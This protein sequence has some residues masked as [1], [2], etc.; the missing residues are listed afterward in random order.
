MQVK[1]YLKNSGSKGLR[2]LFVQ[3]TNNYQRERFHFS[4]IKLNPEH[5]DAKKNE[6]KRSCE[7]YSEL[8]EKIKNYYSRILKV[9]NRFTNENQKFPDRDELKKILTKEFKNQDLVSK[10]DKLKTFWGFYQHFINQSIDGLRK[11]GNGKV[12]SPNTIK[13]YVTLKNLLLSFEEHA[14][15]K[16]NFENIDLEFY[17]DFIEYLEKKKVLKKNTIS[18]HIRT[19]KTV[20][21][22]SHEGEHHQNIKFSSRRF[23]A[24]NEQTTAVYLTEEELKEMLKLDL[25]GKPGLERVRDLFV[26]ACYTALRHS[27]LKQITEDNIKPDHENP[28]HLYLHINKQTKTGQPVIIP[29]HKTV[30]KIIDKYNKKNQVLEPISIQKSNEHLKEIGKLL[31]I[32]NKPFKVEYTK[33]GKEVSVNHP[34]YQLITTHTGRRTFATLSYL[35][36]HKTIDIMAVTG[37]KTESSF[38]RYIRVTPMEKARSFKMYEEGEIEREITSQKL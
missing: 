28:N 36:G 18:K 34:K 33:G 19:L 38:Y 11:T 10:S 31:P 1:F 29:L 3:I 5:W 2:T 16:L 13:C 12:I 20:M 32:L 7:G 15:T 9:V 24:P 37:H 17:Q 25:T 14:K 21:K 6:V 30:L 27:D 4:D 22:E 8:N 23:A 35:K 26:I